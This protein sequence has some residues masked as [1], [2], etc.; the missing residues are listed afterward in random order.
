MME[1]SKFSRFERLDQQPIDA[2]IERCEGI[3][4]HVPAD[5]EPPPPE[6]Q[7]T[8]PQRFF[9]TRCFMQHGLV[10]FPFSLLDTSACSIQ[11]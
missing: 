2:S 4:D 8:G 5:G 9:C 7:S 11:L 1:C 10:E 6:A 3:H